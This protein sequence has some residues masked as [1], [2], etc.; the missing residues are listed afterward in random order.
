MAESYFVKV[1]WEIDAMS[2]NRSYMLISKRNLNV[3]NMK[4]NRF[5]PKTKK[6]LKLFK[7]ISHV[8]SK[9]SDCNDHGSIPRELSCERSYLLQREQEEIQLPDD[10]CKPSAKQ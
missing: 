6:T 3:G 1:K 7:R 9:Y 2:F 8:T 5:Q 4:L 10:I